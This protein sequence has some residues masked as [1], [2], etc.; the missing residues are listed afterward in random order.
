VGI[1][2]VPAEPVDRAALAAALE[3]AQA[4]PST[5]YTAE[6]W[7]RLRDAGVA[8]QAVY[9][10]PEA[11]QEAVDAAVQAIEDALAG[12][13][14]VAYLPLEDYRIAVEVG[15]ELTAESGLPASVVLATISGVQ[16]EVP[17]TW[18]GSPSTEVPYAVSTVSGVANGTPVS[19]SVEVVPEGLVYLVDAAAVKGTNGNNAGIDSPAHAAVKTLREDGLRNQV[20]DQPYDAESGWGLVNPIDSGAGYVSAK[21][22]VAGIYDK[23]A[24][25]GWWAS[26]GGSV[27]YRLTLP[28]GEYELTS[29]YREWWGMTRQVQPSVTVGQETVTGDPVSLSSASLQGT[30]TIRFTVEEE[31]EVLFRAARGTGAADPVLSW[32]AVADVTPRADLAVSAQVTTRCVSGKVV[33]VV[34]A[35]N[36]DTMPVALTL[37]ST[38]GS[39]DLATLAPGKRSST[40]LTT[41]LAEIT[42]GVVT[43]GATATVDG[44]QVEVAKE[45]TYPASAC[46]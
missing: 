22:R 9:D 15:T 4:A 7:Q 40:A 30:S 39:K 31:G 10:D 11:T 38:F 20:A 27:D 29:G 34:T 13:V 23:F 36:D 8:S 46:G 44:A 5:A 2:E 35:A 42:E 32:L 18:S 26:S 37:S 43:L 16:H 6:S 21:A 28:A 19:L 24:T 3:R 14:E 1:S 12:L 17:V 33:L 25:T 41:R 45:V